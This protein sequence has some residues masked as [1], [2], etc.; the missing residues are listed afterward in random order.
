MVEK[1]PELPAELPASIL[2]YAY[3]GDDQPVTKHVDG[4]INAA[5]ISNV[6]HTDWDGLFQQMQE[7]I[8]HIHMQQSPSI[9]QACSFAHPQALTDA[10]DQGN[11]INCP[12]H[13]L[14]TLQPMSLLGA[15][16]HAM[17]EP[18]GVDSDTAEELPGLKTSQKAPCSLLWKQPAAKMQMKQL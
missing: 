17:D 5:F 12:H 4:L 18:V 8:K 2:A 14:Q 6:T 7:S 1:Y 15:D 9:S 13:T 10:A 16:G 11:A 3:A